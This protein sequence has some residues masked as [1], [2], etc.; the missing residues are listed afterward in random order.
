MNK[1][2]LNRE[3]IYTIPES[4]F[5]DNS[6]TLND[7]KVYM[8]IRS[9]MDSHREC[10]ASNKWFAETLDVD[11]RT[12]RG[13][14]SK[15]ETKSYIERLEINRTRVLVT[16]RRGLNMID[17][18]LKCT[19][20]LV[21]KGEDLNVRGGGSSDPGGEDLNVRL[22]TIEVKDNDQRLLLQTEPPKPV[23]V[24]STSPSNPNPKNPSYPIREGIT[25]KLLTAYRNNPILKG[26]IMCEGD[27]LSAAYFSIDERDKNIV[28]EMQRTHGICGL[29]KKGE[30]DEP[31][32]WS[33]SLRRLRNSQIGDA[34]K[35]LQD[36]NMRNH[37]PILT[38]AKGRDENL[39][40]I[41]AKIGKNKE[42]TTYKPV[43]PESTLKKNIK[44]TRK[45]FKKIGLPENSS[46][47]QC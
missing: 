37:A 27:F 13:S 9:F 19:P 34:K 3:F 29:I 20:D 18:D 4:I 46:L 28:T 6:L 23:V 42:Q 47:T 22:S 31:A 44:T 35:E 8:I 38:N 30:F 25:D 26:N 16:K 32:E 5:F 24:T 1:P 36:K 45:L 39:K 7:M 15:L 17:P 14:L 12:I 11:S 40:E 21:C 43:Y 10:F 2:E 33:L 41:M